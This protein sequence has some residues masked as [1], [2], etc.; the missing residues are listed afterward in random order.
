MNRTT[1]L[2]IIR[3]IGGVPS[4]TLQQSTVIYTGSLTAHVAQS[5]VAPTDALSYMVRIGVSNG[6]DVF[7]SVNGTAVIPTGAPSLST[8]ELNIAQ[9]YVAA[10]GTVSIIT[11]TTGVCYS[12]GFYAIV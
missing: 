11:D 2:N 7:V 12:L 1:K 10:G 8:T 6:A 4:Y 3:D 9:T 5:V